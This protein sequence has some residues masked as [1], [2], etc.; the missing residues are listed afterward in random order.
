MYEEPILQFVE[1]KQPDPSNQSNGTPQEQ[2]MG[3]AKFTQKREEKNEK[4]LF[5]VIDEIFFDDFYFILLVQERVFKEFYSFTFPSEYMSSQAFA[6]AMD[7]KLSSTEKTKL[8]AY[9]RAFD[10]QQKS[11]LTYSDY[12]LGE[13]FH[14][15]S[16][17]VSIKYNF[18]TVSLS[19]TC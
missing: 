11:Y 9:F 15:S 4:Q 1:C 12:L 13:C 18:P 8:P 3:S 19:S 7:N 5:K 2:L 10:S 14:F 6:E 17:N 16:I